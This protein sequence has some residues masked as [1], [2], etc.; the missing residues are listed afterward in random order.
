MAARRRAIYSSKGGRARNDVDGGHSSPTP[1]TPRQRQI[2]D[3]IR[4]FLE[5]RGMPPTRAEIAAGL[6]FSTPSSAE[7]HLQALARKGAI[8]LVPGAS[9]GL[10]LLEIAGEPM[11]GTL[12]LVG[13]VAAGAPIL[14]TGHI[15]AHFRVDPDLFAPRADYLL[16]V[17]GTSMCDA[18]ILDGDLLAVHRQSDAL[19][20]QI[21]VARL[22]DD[23][24]VKRLKRRGRD[25][26]LMPENS[27]FV[28]IVV[29]ASDDSFAIEGIAVGLVR[30]G[31]LGEGRSAGRVRGALAGNQQRK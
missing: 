12:P 10:R 30:S 21:V 24:T 28:P 19:S 1:L 3:W 14:A 26:F 11:Q 20:G 7:D 8:E 29:D 15:E 17:R 31:D 5:A 18:G 13:R 6:G 25:I 23:V 4:G 16:R 9:R 22:N 27:R 2:L